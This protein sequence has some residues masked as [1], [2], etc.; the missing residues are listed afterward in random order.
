M[1]ISNSQNLL[2]DF[3]SDF[4]QKQENVFVVSK[5]ESCANVLPNSQARNS[6]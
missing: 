1:K 6:K 3:L 4:S 5:N 2:K